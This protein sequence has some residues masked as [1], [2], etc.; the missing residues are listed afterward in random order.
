MRYVRLFE[1]HE[2][3]KA[4]D[5]KKADDMYWKERVKQ[6]SKD[7]WKKRKKAPRFKDADDERDTLE[8]R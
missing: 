5:K 2:N 8:D 7:A 4:E 6:T 3:K 1:E